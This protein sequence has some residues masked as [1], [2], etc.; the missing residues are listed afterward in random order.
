MSPAPKALTCSGRSEMNVTRKSMFDVR[1]MRIGKKTGSVAKAK[2][3]IGTVQ[4][5]R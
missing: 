5:S 2:P 3:L 4:Y 1:A